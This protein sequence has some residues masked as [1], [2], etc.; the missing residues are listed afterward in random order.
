MSRLALLGSCFLVLGAAL[1]PPARA[2]TCSTSTLTAPAYAF[3]RWCGDPP[4]PGRLRMGRRGGGGEEFLEVPIDTYREVVRTPNV[5][6]Y[7]SEEVLPR[8]R[9]AAEAPASPPSPRSADRAE[10]RARQEH[11]PAP[12]ASAPRREAPAKPI[13][14]AAGARGHDAAVTT[15]VPLVAGAQRP[16]RVRGSEEL[17]PAPRREGHAA[18][19]AGTVPTRPGVCRS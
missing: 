8:F 7:L 4:G 10:G 15:P 14:H 3:A 19:R 11:R 6:R 17:C 1:A 16:V 13:H 9:R 5:A 2:E 12:T 18:A